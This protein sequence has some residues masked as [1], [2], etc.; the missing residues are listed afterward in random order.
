MTAP[1]YKIYIDD[2]GEVRIV[3]MGS[4]QLDGKEYFLGYS[5][6]DIRDANGDEISN[7]EHR[8]RLRLAGRGSK[9]R[10]YGT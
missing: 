5:T 9:L 1:L 8:A 2:T 3:A 4:H 7:Q 6:L 10:P